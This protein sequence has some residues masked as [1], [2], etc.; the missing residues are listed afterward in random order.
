MSKSLFELRSIRVRWEQNKNRKLELMRECL[1][2]LRCRSKNSNNI[3]SYIRRVS[4]RDSEGIAVEIIS[5]E[6][7]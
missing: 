5:H 6:V 1:Q 4:S 7:R 3:Q 2:Q